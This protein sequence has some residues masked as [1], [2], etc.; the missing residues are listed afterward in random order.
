MRTSNIKVTIDMPLPVGV[1][2]CNGFTYTQEAIREAVRTMGG[3]PLMFDDTII[4]VVEAGYVASEA[5]DKSVLRL[6]AVI[7]FGGTLD[8]VTGFD[9]SS[10]AISTYKITGVGLDGDEE[11]E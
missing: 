8:R 1:P 11:D 6:Y 2:D 5:E 3:V 7:P 4:G 9:K 10:Q